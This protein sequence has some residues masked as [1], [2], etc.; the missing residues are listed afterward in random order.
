MTLRALLRP[1]VLIVVASVGA[2][3]VVRQ[4]STQVLSVSAPALLVA[5]RL[6]PSGTSTLTQKARLLIAKSAAAEQA[7][8][9]PRTSLMPGNSK[10]L[11]QAG[12]FARKALI[13]DITQVDAMAIYGL[14]ADARGDHAL[15]KNI[16]LASASLSKRDVLTRLWLIENSAKRNQLSEM[17]GHIDIALRTSAAAQDLMFPLLA[18][19]LSDPSVV[20]DFIPILQRD[21]PWADTFLYTA[22]NTGL[23]SKELAQ[24]MARLDRTYSHDGQPLAPMLM[25]QLIAQRAW[26]Q[27]VEFA[28]GAAG[29]KGDGTHV[30]DP[31]FS[32]G[33]GIEPLNWQLTSSN[34]FD[35]V[36]SA[37]SAGA[38]GLLITSTGTGAEVQKPLAI[39][40][41]GGLI[42][43]T[44]LTLFVLPA[45]SHL[46]LRGRHKHHVTGDY[47]DVDTFGAE[48]PVK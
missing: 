26:P 38:N 33:A 30:T 44:L 31:G 32:S 3:Q 6:A 11:Q 2:F 20:P 46:L 17:L 1:L 41:I 39:V 18:R 23:A 15:A 27:V 47:G 29:F 19:A 13:G 43:S 34:E 25:E 22:I 48:L 28:R 24:I 10:D 45:I 21:P 14:A 16:M 36:R 42:T 37:D 12:L 8:K 7:S 9:K 4:G 5:E 35:A 40:V